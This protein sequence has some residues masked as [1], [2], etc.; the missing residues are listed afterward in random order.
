MPHR[1]SAEGPKSLDE[2]DPELLRLMKSLEY[3]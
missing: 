2:V 3:R 1:K